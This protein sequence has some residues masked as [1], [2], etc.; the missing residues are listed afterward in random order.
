MEIPNSKRCLGIII[1]TLPLTCLLFSA[2][3]SDDENDFCEP[4]KSDYII[5]LSDGEIIQLSDTTTYEL[6]FDNNSATDSIMLCEDCFSPHTRAIS[7]TYMEYGYDSES[8]ETGWKKFYIGNDLIQYGISPG[9]YI[10]RYVKVH[11]NLSILPNKTIVVANYNSTNAPQN[12]MGWY[13]TTTNIGFTATPTSNYVA[14]GVTRVFYIKSSLSG[15]SYNMY[16][17][18]IP[19]NFIWAYTLIDMGDIW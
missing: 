7:E 13:G 10:A 15:V 12:A 18:A 2:C 6:N 19:S 11:K 3:S 9:Y 17:P 14:D 1:S 8:P 5:T 16:I 4:N